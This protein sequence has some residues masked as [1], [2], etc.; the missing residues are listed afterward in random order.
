MTIT[1]YF[2]LSGDV[3]GTQVDL[4]F[5]KYEIGVVFNRFVRI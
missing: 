4:K 1:K 3:L 5:L 2:S